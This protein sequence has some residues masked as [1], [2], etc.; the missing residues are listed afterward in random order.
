MERRDDSISAVKVTLIALGFFSLVW[1]GSCALIGYGT[2]AVVKTAANAAGRGVARV[3]ERLEHQV[4]K[5]RTEEWLEEDVTRNGA[6]H[7]E[8]HH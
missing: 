7:F 1:L 3:E 6:T 8:N 5:A 4:D 2:V